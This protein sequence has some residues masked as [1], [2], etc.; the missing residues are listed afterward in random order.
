M[1]INHNE[2]YEQ[3]REAV[4]R[5]CADFPGEYWRQ[6]DSE[7][8]YPTE[9][10]QALVD[11]GYLSALI[12]EKYGGSGLDLKALCIIL[13]TIHIFSAGCLFLSRPSLD[14]WW[15]ALIFVQWK[16]FC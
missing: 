9:F 7:S 14:L 5:L 13:E 11:T 4:K 16:F 12:P 3:I 8:E 2:S 6:K 1:F 10:V 15:L